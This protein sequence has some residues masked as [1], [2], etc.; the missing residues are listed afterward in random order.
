MFKK[1]CSGAHL[2]FWKFLDVLILQHNLARL[3]VIKHLGNVPPPPRQK[4]YRMIDERLHA[5]VDS[6]D[7]TSNLLSCLDAIA[8]QSVFV[9]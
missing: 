9:I 8:G 7:I 5:I 6:Y 2:S 4:K 3:D 1:F